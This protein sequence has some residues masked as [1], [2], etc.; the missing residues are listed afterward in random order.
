MI[1][2]INEL[3]IIIIKIDFVSGHIIILHGYK[4]GYKY[5]YSYEF[6]NK[7]RL[8][9]KYLAD[10]FI[11]LKINQSHL[12]IMLKNDITIDAIKLFTKKELVEVGLPIGVVVKLLNWAEFFDL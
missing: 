2:Q 11:E 7:E 10:L 12:D 8:E 3:G 5:I 1:N 6:C 9:R 4:Y